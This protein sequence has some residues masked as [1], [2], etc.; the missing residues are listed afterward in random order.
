MYIDEN[1]KWDVHI[2]KIIPKI[3]AKISILRSLRNLVPI[4]TL[5]L[6]YN[7]IV[8]PHFDYSDIVLDSRSAASK[9][10]LQSLQTRA[11]R[12]ITGSGPKTSRNPLY[13]SLS[14]L[15]LQHRQDF[16]KCV[17]VYKC[18]NCLAPSYL[19]KLFT[20]NDTKQTYNNSHSSQLRSTKTR[21]TYYHKSVTV[22]GYKLWNDLP[23]TIQNCTTLSTS[24]KALYKFYLDKTQ[25]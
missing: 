1:L 17:M 21:T 4:D 23:S 12:L 19:E 20:S 5:T 15:S 18:R 7:A 9:F 25:F 10:K 11:A 8:L 6:M 3:S 16:H 22:S 14:W 13:K 24:K 2:D